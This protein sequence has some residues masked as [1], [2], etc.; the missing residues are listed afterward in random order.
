LLLYLFIGEGG[1]T[2]YDVRV[3]VR[4]QLV[5]V[6]PSTM[7]VPGI[8]YG[9]WLDYKCLFQLLSI[10][11]ALLCLKKKKSNYLPSRFS[12]ETISGDANGGLN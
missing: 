7:R 3:E 5:T 1:D 4:G 9:C 8:V 11:M 2:C 12:K 10:L 6:S